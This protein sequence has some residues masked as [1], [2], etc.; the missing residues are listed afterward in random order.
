MTTI[1]NP[2]HDQLNQLMDFGHVVYVGRNADYEPFVTDEW[3][4]PDRHPEECIA[5]WD[6]EGEGDPGDEKL[7][8]AIPEGWTLLTGY[9]GQYGYHGAAMHDSEFIGGGLASAI[10]EHS[11]FYVT[12][13][14]DWYDEGEH[15]E[16]PHTEGWI[17]SYFGPDTV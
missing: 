7:R 12:S 15:K 14:L 9:T 10:L 5:L 3:G 4:T 8:A 2:T 11:G 13:Y 1:V 16:D 17:V 6:P